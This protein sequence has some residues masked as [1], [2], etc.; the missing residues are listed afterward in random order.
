MRHIP[1]ALGATTLASRLGTDHAEFPNS[2]AT[3]RSQSQAVAF[4][5]CGETMRF[6]RFELASHRW[7]NRLRSTFPPTL[8]RLRGSANSRR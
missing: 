3:P 5:M 8:P 7:G 6:I 1:A 2:L 4:P